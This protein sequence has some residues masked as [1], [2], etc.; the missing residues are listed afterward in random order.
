[1]MNARISRDWVRRNPP[2]DVTPKTS[3][4]HRPNFRLRTYIAPL[5]QSGEQVREAAADS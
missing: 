1:M 2:R 4:E 5:D 3:T